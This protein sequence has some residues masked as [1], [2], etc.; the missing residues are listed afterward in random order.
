MKEYGGKETFQ[1]SSKYELLQQ[2]SEHRA[3]G[4]LAFI[5]DI[6][7]LLALALPIS[8]H[9]LGLLGENH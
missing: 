1:N 6:Y 8:V 9:D 3:N 5:F 4:I 7:S 2:V